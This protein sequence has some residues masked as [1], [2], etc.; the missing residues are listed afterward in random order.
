MKF[1]GNK[2]TEN[3]EIL[4]GKHLKER[5]NDILEEG[6]LDEHIDSHGYLILT[7]KWSIE[8]KLR[9]VI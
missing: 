3:E 5:L 1:Q 9:G 6:N 7:D 2:L 8:K 4:I